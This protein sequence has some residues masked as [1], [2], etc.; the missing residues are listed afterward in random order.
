MRSIYWSITAL[1][2]ILLLACLQGQRESPTM[3]QEKSEQKKVIKSKY[4]KKYKQLYNKI[5]NLKSGRSIEALH[6]KVDDLEP[7]LDETF[8]QRMELVNNLLFVLRDKLRVKYEMF[9]QVRGKPAAPDW[10]MLLT[11]ECEYMT[12]VFQALREFRQMDAGDPWIE[13]TLPADLEF[14]IQVVEQNLEESRKNFGRSGKVGSPEPAA[15][16]EEVENK[17]QEARELV[18]E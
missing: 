8:P 15:L 10:T 18:A 5:E 4:W 7:G 2:V 6:D 12:K 3:A 14:S 11:Q 17:L 13:E 1:M 9:H 16:W